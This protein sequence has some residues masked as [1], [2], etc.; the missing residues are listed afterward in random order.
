MNFKDPD[1]IKKEKKSKYIIIHSF[2]V[3]KVL[4]T[5]SID[6]F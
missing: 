4:I 2:A 1:E 5:Y 6:I 3:K